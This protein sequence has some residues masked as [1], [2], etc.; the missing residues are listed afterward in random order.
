MPAPSP[1]VLSAS[2]DALLPGEPGDPSQPPASALGVDRHVTGLIASLPAAQRAE[3]DSLFRAFDGTFANLLLTGRLQ[4]FSRLEPR[5][6]EA[7][8]GRWSTSRLA[9]KRKGFQAL[10]RLIAWSYFTAT[11]PDGTNP[12]WSA[13]HYRPPGPVSGLDDPLAGI[14]PRV[15]DRDV[16]EIC[17]VAV[18]GSGAGGCVV[19]DRAASAGQRV[20]VIESGPWFASAEYPRTEREGFDRLYLGRGLV[21]TRDSAIAVLA[22][23]GAGGGTTVNWM[24]CLS[25]RAEA[26]AEWA[27]AGSGGPT[28]GEFDRALAAVSARLD[29]SRAES[30]INP[31][32]DVLRTGSLA[33]GY[34]E[35]V[36]WE[37]IA[38]NAVGCAGRCGF[39]MFGCRYGARRSA[40]S[41]YLVAALRHGAAIYCGTRA[42][43]IEIEGGRARRVLAEFRAGGV[44][45]AVRVRA[46]AIVVAA[47]ALQTPGILQRSGLRSP[48]IGQ[49]LRLDPTTAMVGEFS[50]PMRTWEGPPQ[51][52]AV[53]RFQTAD[54]GAHGPWIEAAPAHPGLAALATPWRDAADYRR[55]V[56]RLEYVATPIVLV[57]DVAEGRVGADAE[58]RPILDYR[59]GRRD[60]ENL[61]RGMVETARILAAAGATRLLSLHTP[62]VEVG[63]GASPVRPAE[64]DRFVEAIRSAGVR[65]HSLALFSAHPMG[66]ARVGADPRRSAARP[67]GAVHGVEGLWIADGSLLPSAPGANPMVSILAWAERVSDHLLAELAGAPALAG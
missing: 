7:Y 2:A 39:C 14:R 5:A 16:E 3:F 54:D 24:T 21:T 33:L 20:V 15:P 30:T 57:R 66:S 12:R 49:G 62:P 1:G 64:V 60:R 19:A 13:L 9:L 42:T 51:T 61:V 31:P 48:G 50:R 17:D 55:L 8:L 11:G 59:L 23:V 34:R 18:I 26:R 32:N 22:G 56:A 29:V 47:G 41:T 46:R 4:R 43:S 35:G 10:K 53:R 6:R 38:R 58:G 36:D 37:V 44:R 45:R 52:I 67:S 25:P 65:E 27:E 63:D 28:D 40:L